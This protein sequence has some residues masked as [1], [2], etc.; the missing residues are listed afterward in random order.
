MTHLAT[1]P[2]VSVTSQERALITIEFAPDIHP[3]E[4]QYNYE[5]PQF[6]F[7]GRVELRGTSFS[8]PPIIF[9]ICG[10]EIIESKTRSGKLLTQPRWKYKIS[11]GE[12]SFWKEESALIRYKDK[13]S[14]S[15]C[16]AWSV[17][18]AFPTEVNKLDRDGYP[19]EFAEPTG[20]F[21]TDFVSNS[22]ELF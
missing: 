8:Y 10:M 1:E 3:E 13:S 15:T 18:E 22:D 4:T 17:I 9:T 7:G 12:V 20:Y 5:H 19:M 16:S 14:L 21:S 6:V 11:N 2:V